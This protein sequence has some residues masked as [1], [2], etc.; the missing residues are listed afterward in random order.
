MP[1]HVVVLIAVM[2]CILSALVG[3]CIGS[4][5]PGSITL[6]LTTCVM[7]DLSNTPYRFLIFLRRRHLAAQQAASHVVIHV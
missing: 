5:K 2:S 7:S 6:G 3:L 4:E 1:K